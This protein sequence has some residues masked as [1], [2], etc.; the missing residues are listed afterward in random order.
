[1]PRDKSVERS[2]SVCAKA[3]VS[4][5]NGHQIYEKRSSPIQ[6]GDSKLLRC[7]GQNTIKLSFFG[8]I[9]FLLLR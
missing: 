9:F 2:R 1:M 5:L 7:L 3:M 4:L 6:T 8:N